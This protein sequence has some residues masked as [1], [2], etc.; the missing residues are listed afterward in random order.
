[1]AQ[2]GH[3]TIDQTG[4]W[5]Y[6]ADN[7]QSAIQQLNTGQ[8][9]TDSFTVHSADGTSHTIT[10]TIQGQDDGPA[11][12]PPAHPTQSD[13][14]YMQI[15]HALQSM[16][17]PNFKYLGGMLLRDDVNNYPFETALVVI[18]NAGVALISPDGTVAKAFGDPRGTITEVPIMEM[19]NWHDKGPGYKVVFTDAKAPEISIYAHNQGNPG[20]LSGHYPYTD[21]V[22]HP[23]HSAVQLT[24]VMHEL[25]GASPPAPPV[26]YAAA[27]P[28]ADHDPLHDQAIGHDAHAGAAVDVGGSHPP[29][30][31]HPDQVHT[32]HDGVTPPPMVPEP[33]HA[34][35]QD[36]AH[37][38]AHDLGAQH[39]T[40]VP[41]SEQPTESQPPEPVPITPHPDAL[42]PYLQ[43]AAVQGDGAADPLAHPDQGG[44]SAVDDYL[45]AAGVSP[46]EV[47]PQHE[48][49]LPPD[50]IMNDMD[51]AHVHA[52]P[53]HTDPAIDPALDVPV[54]HPDL[55][56][57]H[58]DNPIYGD[59][60]H[61]GG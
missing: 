8:H 58:Q 12:T 50:S 48:P 7:K 59:P 13:D 41:L 3:Y 38:T 45:A 6:E 56:N 32:G 28:L 55:L 27:P 14:V 33:V 51:P 9:L 1:G 22:L 49:D 40:D 15:G 4:F 30:A 23:D 47:A 61:H 26:D 19:I 21:W 20:M 2:Y 43:F 37:D 25:T 5:L 53:D 54:V 24:P 11:W 29:A 39:P 35:V 46:D 60:N 10:V 34:P 52:S 42:T 57:D 17:H 16:V 44:T 36:A 31:E 18:K